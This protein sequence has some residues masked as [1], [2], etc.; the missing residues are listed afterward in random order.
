MKN[1]RSKALI[2]LA[3]LASLTLTGC[4]VNQ[5]LENSLKVSP[6]MDKQQVVAA[7][8]DEPVATEFSGSLEEWHYCN[9]GMN[10]ISKY[11]AIFFD[12]G[13]V[14]AMKPYSVV[15]RDAGGNAFAVCEEFIKMGSYQEPD[16][17]KEYRIKYR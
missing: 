13:R 14:I 17:V 9:T 8:G 4:G 7:M 12:S 15:E 16:V 6:G 3:A 1:Q 5:R 11:V 2:F 10:G